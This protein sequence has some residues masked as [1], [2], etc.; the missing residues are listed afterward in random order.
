MTTTSTTLKP[1]PTLEHLLE[2]IKRVHD[3]H[4]DD[5]CWMDIDLIF[6]AAGLPV[7]DRKVGDRFEMLRNCSRYIGGMCSDGG[8]W[9][10]YTQL[11]GDLAALKYAVGLLPEYT[12]DDIAGAVAR[13]NV[14]KAS[15]RIP[16]T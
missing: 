16:P 1:P 9:V 6:E 12:Q 11:E 10:S 4:A 3:S 15:A 8:P 5:L 13:H 7:P 14:E 2:V